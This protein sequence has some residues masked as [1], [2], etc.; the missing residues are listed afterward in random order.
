VNAGRLGG[1][2]VIAGAVTLG[3]GTGA[4][5]VLSPGKRAGKLGILTIQGAL[6]FNS[7]SKYNCG[8]ATKRAV[9]DKVIANGVTINGAQF[10]LLDAGNGVLGPGTAF[11]VIYNKSATAIAGTFSNLADGS[12]FTAGSNTFQASYEGGDGNDFTLTVL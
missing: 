8:L 7:D 1:N 4:G 11:T 5:A 10:D 12:T 6:T 9:A 2:G 3:T